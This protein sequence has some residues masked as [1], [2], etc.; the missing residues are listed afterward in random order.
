MPCQIKI[1]NEWIIYQNLDCF[2][3]FGKKKRLSSTLAIK[4]KAE[5]RGYHDVSSH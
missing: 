5:A 1:V 3:E 4:P 2:K